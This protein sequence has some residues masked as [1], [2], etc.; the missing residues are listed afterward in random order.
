MNARPGSRWG[1]G[2]APAVTSVHEERTGSMTEREQTM[3]RLVGLV[4]HALG[5]VAVVAALA[6]AG[7]PPLMAGVTM[8]VVGGAWG[9]GM[10]V[11]AARADAER[12]RRAEQERNYR[13]RTGTTFRSTFDDQPEPSAPIVPPPGGP[14]AVPLKPWTP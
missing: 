14:G 7:W 9:W 3:I 1:T 5:L 11:A 8:F 2:G 4:V 13:E 6:G 10:V 12:E